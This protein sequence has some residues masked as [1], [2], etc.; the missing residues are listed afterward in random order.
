MSENLIGYIA[1][2]A[3]GLPYQPTLGR[4]WRARTKPITVYKYEKYAKQFTGYAIPV[5]TR[6]VNE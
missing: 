6:D 5:Y 4:G 2:D 3:D 1:V